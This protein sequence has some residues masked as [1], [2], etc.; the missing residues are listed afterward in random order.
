VAVGAGIRHADVHAGTSGLLFEFMW[1]SLDPR[2]GTAA[3]GTRGT[4]GRRASRRALLQ[5]EARPQRIGDERQ[6]LP[7]GRH[8]DG[9]RHVLLPRL[10][11][12]APR[13]E[14]REAGG[15]LRLA[16]APP[17]RSY[18]PKFLRALSS[19][20][21]AVA[22]VPSPTA[23]RPAIAAMKSTHSLPFQARL[24]GA[25]ADRH[26]DLGGRSRAARSRKSP[27]LRAG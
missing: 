11:A 1:E 2:R 8:D 22:L 21:D 17:G 4:R 20:V 27:A 16:Q 12:A 6:L 25:D 26:V 23:S 5:T 7:R 14:E 10:R 13:H 9:D 24:G 18:A 3:D 15:P 19:T